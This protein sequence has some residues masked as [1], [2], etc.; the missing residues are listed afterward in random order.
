MSAKDIQQLVQYVTDSQGAQIGVVVP[1]ALWEQI[2]M[3]LE[4]R[5][6][7]LDALDEDEPNARILSDLEESVR[8]SRA[9][10]VFPIAQ[11]WDQVYE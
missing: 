1:I 11:L 2:L 6:S 10:K 3:A 8:S 5:E 9:G 4:R 7:G